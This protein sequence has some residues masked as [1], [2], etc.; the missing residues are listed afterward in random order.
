MPQSRLTLDASAVESQGDDELSAD[1]SQGLPWWR[2]AYGNLRA[3]FNKFLA[4]VE[5][6]EIPAPAE[7]SSCRRLS[8][9][10]R[11]FFI[12]FFTLAYA[13]RHFA[14]LVIDCLLLLQSSWSGK[15]LG[16]DAVY[17]LLSIRKRQSGRLARLILE[18]SRDECPYQLRSATASLQD[19]YPP[20]VAAI[21]LDDVRHRR[22]N[23]QFDLCGLACMLIF[24]H[25]FIALILHVTY[26]SGQGWIMVL[27][28]WGV[29]AIF[30]LIFC[31]NF[32]VDGDGVLT[33]ARRPDK[34]IPGSAVLLDQDFTV[35]LNGNQNI[36][37][38]V[39]ESGFNLS[40]LS[41]MWKLLRGENRARYLLFYFL[42][43]LCDIACLFFLTL[44]SSLLSSISPRSSV[45]AMC[46]FFTVTFIMIFRSGMLS[47]CRLPDLWSLV[48]M[49]MLPVSCMTLQFLQADVAAVQLVESIK[50]QFLAH[51]LSF[52]YTLL[53]TISM[54]PNYPIRT[55]KLLDALGHP[56]VRKWQ[57][58]THAAAAT[59]QCLVICRG[60]SRPIRSID[61]ST[62]LDMLIPDQRDVWKAWKDRVADRIVHD[63]DINFAPTIPTFGD[64]RQKQ[65]KDLLDQAQSGYKT[66]G[67]FFN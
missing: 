42:Q 25:I 43:A 4:T 66:Y 30:C 53:S 34:S 56:R 12:R 14:P 20:C 6:P 19:I 32:V 64:E 47:T 59:F 57:F 24:F 26:L 67:C 65:L 60:I 10:L 21:D 35:V 9:N 11:T 46:I 18:Y 62:F 23:I 41:S 45:I 48:Y 15:Q 28:S 38:A 13:P 16:P 8:K 5:S 17:P 61:V 52:L 3:F 22:Y 54:A 39:I 7:S 44:C 29:C 31:I 58:D 33:L 55:A 27:C 36:V 1:V 40:H 50:W 63:T 49:R 51:F 2:R 37:E